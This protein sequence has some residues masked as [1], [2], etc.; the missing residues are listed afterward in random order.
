MKTNVKNNAATEIYKSAH[1]SLR[2]N[3]PGGIIQCRWDETTLVTPRC[4]NAFFS[5]FVQAGG[6][7][8]QLVESCPLRYSSNNAPSVCGVLATLFSGILEGH[9]RY[10]HLDVLHHDPVLPTIYGVEKLVCCDSARR[11]IRK[12]SEDDP[13][14]ALEWA[15]SANIRNLTPLLDQPYVLDL[16]PTVKPLYG[17]QEG[18]VLGYNPH[19]PGRPSH[20]YHT[21]CIAELRLVLG[22]VVHPGNQTSGMHSMGMLGHFLRTLPAPLRPRFARGDVVFGVD[23]V[24]EDCESNGVKYLFKL[25]RTPA[26]TRMWRQ[27]LAP[28]VEWVDA[29]QGWEGCEAS[30]QLDGWRC[31]RRA[32]FVRRPRPL[33]QDRGMEPGGRAG[34]AAETGQMEFQFP[35]LEVLPPGDCGGYDW[36]V[37]VTDLDH[38]ILPLAQ[39]YRDRGNCENIFDEMKN[40][41]GWCGFTTQSLERCGVMA[42][43]VALVANLW[44]IFCR[45]MA[46]ER[47][48]EAKTSRPLLQQV[49]GRLTTHGG[50]K[51]LVCSAS[52]QGKAR[53]M[54]TDIMLKINEISTATQLSGEER[55]KLVLW[56]AFRK[57]NLINTCF[58]PQIGGQLML[59]L[60]HPG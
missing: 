31:A 45:T 56:Y 59:P 8:D 14:A 47:H 24:M 18:A 2:I 57:Y 49:V 1:D 60:A 32:V 55:W 21:M 17:S 54:Y 9:S 42:A 23:N 36:H 5:H 48:A 4:H 16:D 28:G 50:Q 25:R 51:Y 35:D 52:G 19:K 40:Q 26:V 46:P 13:G 30:L 37:L 58:P 43:L 29:G 3:T 11:A 12:M 38:Q 39:L 15:W 41:W 22:V 6:A 10:R 53:D 33:S 20:C 27:C 44:N 7:F 34:K